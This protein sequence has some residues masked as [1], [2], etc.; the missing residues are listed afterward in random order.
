MSHPLSPSSPMTPFLRCFLVLM[1]PVESLF[2]LFAP[3][4][5]LN[6]I[7]FLFSLFCLF[8]VFS[9]FFRLLPFL[10]IRLQPP[11]LLFSPRRSSFFFPLRV[12]W[13]MC[14]IYSALNCEPSFKLISKEKWWIFAH[15]NPH[16]TFVVALLSILCKL[17]WFFGKAFKK[18]SSEGKKRA[19]QE[20]GSTRS[21][22]KEKINFYFPYASFPSACG[23]H[24]DMRDWVSL[25]WRFHFR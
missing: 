3:Q 23:F 25:R 12:C 9:F 20:R 17:W 10:F 21:K 19:P 18:R 7:K 24:S 2:S 6:V 13:A 8:Y 1:I 14:V 4:H 5:R 11:S 15:S 16:I 22:N